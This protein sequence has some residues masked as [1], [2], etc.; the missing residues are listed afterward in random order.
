MS[1]AMIMHLISP[2]KAV[3][4]L[5]YPRGRPCVCVCTHTRIAG[6]KFNIEVACM[7][8]DIMEACWCFHKLPLLYYH[9]MNLLSITIAAQIFTKILT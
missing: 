7:K 6:V 5:A 8:K 4:I 1:S 9:T 2:V 3:W